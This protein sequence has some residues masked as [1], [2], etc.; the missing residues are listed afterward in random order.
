[1]ERECSNCA[2]LSDCHEVTERMIVERGCCRLFVMAEQAVL[3]ARADIIRECGLRALRYA[4]PHR[5]ITSAKPK[6][7]RRKRHV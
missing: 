5:K 3:D 6:P 4:I 1:M 7:R 2:D